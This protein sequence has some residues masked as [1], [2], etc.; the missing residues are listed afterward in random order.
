MG[1]NSGFKG[2]IQVIY[3]TAKTTVVVAL[4]EVLN[5]DIYNFYCCTV[6]VVIITAFIPTHAH[7]HTFHI[8][9]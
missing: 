4:F 9:T 3:F 5:K 7:I 1:F 2:L 6:H 8:N